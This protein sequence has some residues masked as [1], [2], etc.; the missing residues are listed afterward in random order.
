MA[1]V[2][3]AQAG[4]A[5]AVAVLEDLH[6]ADTSTCDLLVFLA[7]ALRETAV[8]ILTTFRSDEPEPG[9]APTAMLTELTRCW[10][11]CAACRSPGWSP[12]STMRW[13]ALRRGVVSMDEL[14]VLSSPYATAEQSAFRDGARTSGD[15]LFPGVRLPQIGKSPLERGRGV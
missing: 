11:R 14:P 3:T 7:R 4:P 8:L 6:W 5:P 2:L 12:G 10:R 1:D 13:C 9:V 15:S